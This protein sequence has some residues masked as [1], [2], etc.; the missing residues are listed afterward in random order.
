MSAPFSVSIKS[1]PFSI[2]MKLVIIP[3]P[4]PG[5][6]G[7]A[8][9]AFAVPKIVGMIIYYCNAIIS[10]AVVFV[11]FTLCTDTGSHDALPIFA[12]ITSLS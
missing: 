4:A 2:R 12:K 3:P 10:V 5:V 7:I 11:L 6:L 8:R 9:I 1:T